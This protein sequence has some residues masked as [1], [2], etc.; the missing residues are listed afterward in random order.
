MIVSGVGC[1]IW[2]AVYI[3]QVLV[4]PL[5]MLAIKLAEPP[6]TVRAYV[7]FVVAD[8]RLETFVRSV[9]GVASRHGFA[10]TAGKDDGSFQSHNPRRLNVDRRYERADGVKITLSNKHNAQ[11]IR[12]W[13][14]DQKR[15]G[16]WRQVLNDVR[17]ATADFEQ[18]ETVANRDPEWP[19]RMGKP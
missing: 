14:D 13:M 19:R 17:A 11:S 8:D 5:I 9:D 4:T 10:V 15:T 16:P 7:S 2:F 1:V 6:D 18:E 12:L 3:M